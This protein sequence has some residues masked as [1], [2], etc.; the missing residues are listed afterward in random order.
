METLAD[1]WPPDN[2]GDTAVARDPSP[3]S[4]GTLRAQEPD[5]NTPAGSVAAPYSSCG[6]VLPHLGAHG[7]GINDTEVLPDPETLHTPPVGP[8]DGVCKIPEAELPHKYPSGNCVGHDVKVC[9]PL[10]TST[11]CSTP[12]TPTDLDGVHTAEVGDADGGSRGQPFIDL[13]LGEWDPKDLLEI[14]FSNQPG[15]ALLGQHPIQEVIDLEVRVLQGSPSPFTRA[16]AKLVLEEQREPVLITGLNLVGWL[17]VLGALGGAEDADLY[18]TISRGFKVLP[19]DINKPSTYQRNY[20]SVKEHWEGFSSSM[21]DYWQKNVLGAWVHVRGATEDGHLERPWDVNAMGAVPKKC[22][23]IRVITDCSKPDYY[24]INDYIEHKHIK[25]SSVWCA[26][27]H[28]RPGGWMWGVDLEDGY[29]HITLSPHSWKHL[30]VRWGKT[31]LAFLKLCF[32]LRNAPG[33]FHKFSGSLVRWA[34]V[35]GISPMEYFL[36]DFWGYHETREGAGEHLNLFLSLLDSLGVKVKWSKVCTPTQ[37]IIYLGIVID[38]V[39]MVLSLDAAKVKKVWRVIEEFCESKSPSV[40]CARSL[41]GLLNHVCIVVPAC[42]PWMRALL[43][44]LKGTPKKRDRVLVSDSMRSDFKY[45]KGVLLELY[46]ARPLAN[47][48]GRTSAKMETDACTSWGMGWCCLTNGQ[49]RLQAWSSEQ[50]PWHINVME[51]YAV[52]DAVRHLRFKN[53]ALY[54]QVD[55]TVTKGWCKKLGAS[56]IQPTLLLRE[57]VEVLLQDNSYMV[58]TWV[59]SKTNRRADALSRN[60]MIDFIAAWA[61]VDVPYVLV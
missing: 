19:K 50:A 18:W 61:G 55:N 58:V 59:D 38:T 43:D 53:S 13:R 33:V 34:K 8:S 35:L 4:P 60:D 28:V 29:F 46:N 56:S 41:A 54:I 36:D 10:P 52:L 49:C 37:V 2:S 14:Q 23:A 48:I 20:H 6:E 32:G 45:I 39:N 3:A 42:K 44:L 21:D 26:A 1:C 15:R 47:A 27:A 31:Y 9:E 30:G 17:L 16:L 24:S 25:M 51:L 11:P 7:Y 57:L 5:C 12:V 22:G 40:T